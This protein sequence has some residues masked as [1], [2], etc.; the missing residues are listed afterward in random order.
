MA[1]P[2]NIGILEL[3]CYLVW[4]LRYTHFMGV[5]RHLEFCTSGFLP[6]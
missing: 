3:R 2:K 4:E 5:G 1:D 6:V